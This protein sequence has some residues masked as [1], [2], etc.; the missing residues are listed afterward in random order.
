M[1]QEGD[2]RQNEREGA[3]QRDD[4]PF[5]TYYGMHT[6]VAVAKTLHGGQQ[7]SSH[8]RNLSIRA[9]DKSYEDSSDSSTDHLDPMRDGLGWFHGKIKVENS[10]QWSKNY[11]IQTIMFILFIAGCVATV[12]LANNDAGASVGLLCGSILTILACTAV[13]FTFLS[14]PTWKKHPN[15]LIFFRSLCDLGLVFVLLTT[16]LYKCSN[17]NCNRQIT[18]TGCST[19]AG[20]TQFFLWASESWFFVMAI[21]MFNSL[22]SPFTDYRRNVRRYHMFVWL[23]AAITA[24]LLMS[25]PGFAGPSDFGYCW[26]AKRNKVENRDNSHKPSGNLWVLNFP[27]VLCVVGFRN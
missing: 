9:L 7:Q 4:G 20:L 13:L 24:I 11:K 6:P 14:R 17:G 21:D 2:L 23:T 26:T 19:T 16:E 12:M 27:Y 15:P 1:I 22:K 3:F 10:I 18:E 8:A 5:S 25:V